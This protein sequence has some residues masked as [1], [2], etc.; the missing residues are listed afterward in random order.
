MEG[1]LQDVVDA[2]QAARQ[3]EQLAELEIGGAP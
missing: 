1:D 2:L 3:A